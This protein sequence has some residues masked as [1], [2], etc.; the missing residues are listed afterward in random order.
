MYE[1]SSVTDDLQEMLSLLKN[2]NDK[3][4]K[5]K[6]KKNRMSSATISLSALRVGSYCIASQQ[7]KPRKTV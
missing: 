7:M 6:K 2:N 3:K 1:A 5:K 4:K